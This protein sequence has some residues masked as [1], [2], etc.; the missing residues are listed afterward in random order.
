MLGVVTALALVALAMWAR[1]AEV[2]R[3][4]RRWTTISAWLV[5][6]QVGLGFASVL[7]VLA[8]VPVSVHTLVAAS[9]LV[10]TVHVATTAGQVEA[11]S[12]MP[13]KVG[14]R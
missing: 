2:P 3:P 5:V 13:E 4:M 14:S 12:E 10:I 6:G 9:L 7:S 8:V 1:K 11:P